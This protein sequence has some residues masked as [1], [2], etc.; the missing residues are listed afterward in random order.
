VKITVKLRSKQCVLPFDQAFGGCT[1][2]PGCSLSPAAK[3]NLAGEA[4]R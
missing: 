4:V 3:P 2:G 1:F